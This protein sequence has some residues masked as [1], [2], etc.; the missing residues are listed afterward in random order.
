MYFNLKQLHREARSKRERFEERQRGFLRLSPRQ[1]RLREQVR[2]WCQRFFQSFIYITIAESGIPLFL[3]SVL[4]R[5]GESVERV[6][7]GRDPGGVLRPRRLS[8]D[9]GARDRRVVWVDKEG[10]RL[11]ERIVSTLVSRL[12]THC[13]FSE[14]LV[15]GFFASS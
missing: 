4:V 2:K 8:P 9:D 11:S 1:P 12:S 3:Q 13:H 6:L 7:L 10:D 5:A 15:P 14:F